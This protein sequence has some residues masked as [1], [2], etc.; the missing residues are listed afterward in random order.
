M[1]RPSFS[2]YSRPLQSYNFDQDKYEKIWTRTAPVSTVGGWCLSIYIYVTKVII[3]IV[4]IIVY[5]M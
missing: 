5:K 1:I 2:M 4:I 3:I